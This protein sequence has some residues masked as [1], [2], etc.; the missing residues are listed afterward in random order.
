M[1]GRRRRLSSDPRQLKASLSTSR[2]WCR[3]RARS[4]RLA[5]R[6]SAR[7]SATRS[8]RATSFS[9]SASSSRWRSSNIP[10]PPPPAHHFSLRIPA[11]YRRVSRQVLY[12][13]LRRRVGARA[14]RVD[15][16][17]LQLARLHRREGPCP[18][19]CRLTVRIQRR[20]SLNASS[21]LSVTGL[22]RLVS[23]GRAD[24]PRRALEGQARALRAR[25]H[26]RRLQVPLRTL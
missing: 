11:P 9:A 26:R 15:R 25:Q 21:S 17:L 16:P 3:R 2:T 4:C 1:R 13:R 22:S 7:R 23:A 6:R 19:C 14:Q 18:R 5:S 8:R 10:P 20:L 24:R 12:R